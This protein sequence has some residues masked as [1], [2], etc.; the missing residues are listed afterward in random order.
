[1]PQKPVFIPHAALNTPVLFLIYN[2]PNVTKKVFSEI[3]KAKPKRLY[4]AADGPRFD[5]IEEKKL[6]KDARSVLNDIDWECETKTLIRDK[7]LGCR[8]AIYEAINWFFEN[9]SEGIITPL[10]FM[11]LESI[12]S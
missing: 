12:I 5:N 4:V 6:C 9:E 10:L 11:K 7:N 8:K 2:R 3:Q 1:M